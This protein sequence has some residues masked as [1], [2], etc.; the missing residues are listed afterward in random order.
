MN[1]FFPTAPSHLI[2]ST[3]YKTIIVLY[4]VCPALVSLMPS[5]T[6]ITITPLHVG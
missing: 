6:Q 3:T 5:L 4:V 2:C 1:N